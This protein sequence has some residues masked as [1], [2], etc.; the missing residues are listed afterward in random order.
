MF[1]Y[2]SA[3][4]WLL[5]P[6]QRYWESGTPPAAIIPQ[7]D[8]AK[9]NIII[10]GAGKNNDARLSPVARLNPLALMRLTEGIRLYRM[11]P[12]AKLVCSGPYGTGK[13]S[14]GELMRNAA[15]SLGVPAA[16]IVAQSEGTNTET[17][18]STY[19]FRHG[20]ETPLVICT[21][22]L[23]MRRAIAW[24][25]YHGVRRIYP[26]PVDFKAPLGDKITFSTFLPDIGYWSSWQQLM[27]EILGCILIF[28]TVR[29]T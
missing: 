10:L 20:T 15:I 11:L 7:G 12:A 2:L 14:Q 8:S 3:T 4:P 25:R 23:H 22:A 28:N 21:S 6:A 5:R 27:K 26:A 16:H 13:V 19:V 24:F 1:F 9:I 29:T 18:A 17:E